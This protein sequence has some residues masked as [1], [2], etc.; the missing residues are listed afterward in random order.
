VAIVTAAATHCPLSIVM[1]LQLRMRDD[2][3]DRPTK[4]ITV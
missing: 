2:M 1:A 3:A 4:L